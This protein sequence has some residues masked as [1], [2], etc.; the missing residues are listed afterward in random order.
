MELL[1]SSNPISKTKTNVLYF[2]PNGTLIHTLNL[3]PKNI[4][5]LRDFCSVRSKIFIEKLRHEVVP[6]VINLSDSSC[7]SALV[8]KKNFD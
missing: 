8:A 4:L 2:V 5:S 1:S 7:F 6:K 3:F